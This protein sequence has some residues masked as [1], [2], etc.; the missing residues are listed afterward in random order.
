MLAGWSPRLRSCIRKMQPKDL[1]CLAWMKTMITLRKPSI[2]GPRAKEPWPNFHAGKEIREKFPEHGIPYFVL[3]DSSGKITFSQ[4]GLD[5]NSLR[6][7][8]AA[9]TSSSTSRSKS[10]H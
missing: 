2:F 7:A 10:T 6:T 1:C 8:V 9:L 5:E 4:A 3:L